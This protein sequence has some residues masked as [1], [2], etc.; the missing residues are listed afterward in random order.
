V[1]LKNHAREIVSID[2]MVVPTVRF[3]ILYMLRFLSIA[4]RRVIHFY[5]AVTEYRTAAWSAQQV[6]EAF[7][8]NTAPKYILGDRDRVYGD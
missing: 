2:F 6:V 1:F 4:R 5:F 8:W 3:Q 7:P